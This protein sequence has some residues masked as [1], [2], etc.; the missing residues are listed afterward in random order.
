MPTVTLEPRFYELGPFGAQ[1]EAL[2]QDL[3]GQGILVAIEREVEERGAGE[4]PHTAWDL[5][6][7]LGDDAT[8]A[9][10]GAIIAAL[11]ARLRGKAWLGPNRGKARRVEIYGPRGELLREVELPGDQAEGEQPAHR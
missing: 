4:I 7:H 2:L 5:A 3:E 6:V 9:L 8:T 11:L 10:L 1:Y